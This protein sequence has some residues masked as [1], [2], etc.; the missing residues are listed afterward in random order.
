VQYFQAT[1]EADGSPG[2]APLPPLP[3]VRTP[4]HFLQGMVAAEIDV[5]EVRGQDPRFTSALPPFRRQASLLRSV[6]VA[7]EVACERVTDNGVL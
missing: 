1:V 3:V 2:R 4:E 7:G 5:Y 6:T